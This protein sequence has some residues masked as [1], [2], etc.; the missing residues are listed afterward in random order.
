MTIDF[1][2]KIDRFVGTFI[3]WILSLFYFYRKPEKVT[4]PANIGNILVILLSEMGS[5]VLAYPMYQYLK[6][7]FPGTPFYVLLF[8]SNR[9]VVEVLDVIP[10]DHILTINN[11]SMRRFIRDTMYA[12]KKMRRI[13]FDIVIDCE[14]FSRFSSILSFLSGAIVRVGFHPYTQE[15]LYRGSFINRR[16]LYNPYHHIS[17]QFINL[18]DAVNSNTIPTP[19]RPVVSRKVRAPYVHFTQEEIGRMK[20]R[21]CDD[22]P[23]IRNRKLVLIYAGGGAL[24]IR[25]WPLPYFCQLASELLRRGYAVGVIGLKKDKDLGNAILS[26][27]KNP[28]CV[29]LTGYTRTIRELMS[30]FHFASLLITNDG[31]P[32]HFAAMTP[33]P[34]IIFYGPETPSLY[35]PLDEKAA[36]FYAGLSCSPCLTAYNHRNSPCDGDNVCLKSIHPDEVLAKALEMLDGQR[37]AA[38]LRHKYDRGSSSTDRRTS[39]AR[40]GRHQ[41]R[42]EISG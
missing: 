18:V 26:R 42:S 16:V 40:T 6:N 30:I 5:H 37:I 7:R 1:Q 10:S 19:K 33:I 2:R 20:R 35:G 4:V 27:C 12:L 21:L 3:C 36:I 13:K 31:G 38:P 29:D 11:E 34:S 9:E 24:P 39:F 22:F 41:R 28:H 23:E 14:L 32:G 15:G 25:A 17:Q 8:E